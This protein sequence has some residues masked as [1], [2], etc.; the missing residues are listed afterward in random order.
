MFVPHA[1]EIW[2]RSYVPNNAKFRAFDKKLCFIKPF[3]KSIDAI[4][5]DVS[6]AESIV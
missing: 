2:T 5:E 4:V 3:W 1:S 6:V